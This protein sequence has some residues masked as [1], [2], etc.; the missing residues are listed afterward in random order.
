MEYLSNYRQVHRGRNEG[1][2]GDSPKNRL[3]KNQKKVFFLCHG[4]AKLL[5]CAECA[6][7]SH[8]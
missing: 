6:W 2:S 4:G 7:G 5:R 1:P 8:G 3:E